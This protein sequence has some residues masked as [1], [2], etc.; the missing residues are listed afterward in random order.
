M[1][2]VAKELVQQTAKSR[3]LRWIGWLTEPGRGAPSIPHPGSHV[4]ISVFNSP[5][6][7]WRMRH[8]RLVRV[9]RLPYWGTGDE[10]RPELSKWFSWLA[11]GED[12]PPQ[13]L[14]RQSSHTQ[15]HISSSPWLQTLFRKRST[16]QGPMPPGLP[17]SHHP[18]SSIQPPFSRLWEVVDCRHDGVK[19][20]L[21]VTRN[22]ARWCWKRAKVIWERTSESHVPPSPKAPSSDSSHSCVFQ[23]WVGTPASTLFHKSPIM[24]FEIRN[25][26]SFSRA[27]IEET[28]K[29]KWNS[30]RS[31]SAILISN[32]LLQ[33][34]LRKRPNPLR[35][36]LISLMSIRGQTN[37]QKRGHD[38]RSTESE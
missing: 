31:L 18:S 35:Q 15:C 34:E 37:A 16:D 21:W 22:V 33:Q 28:H 7:S 10:D 17:P 26:L 14:S 27:A 20:Y 4:A 13:E 5:P 1:A 2:P 6:L 19:D 25:M 8:M 3:F 29:Q 36:Q 38:F 30:Y 12:L 9:A 11:Q 24:G 23:P 32:F